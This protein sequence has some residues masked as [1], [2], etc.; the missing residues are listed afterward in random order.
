MIFDEGSNPLK[1]WNTTVGAAAALTLLGACG[2]GFADQ[3][4]KEITDAA[5][6]DMK[7]LSSV[8]MQGDIASEGQEVS[9]DLRVDTDA[10]CQGEIEMMGGT[11]EILSIDGT[12]WFRPDE[13]FWKASAG[14]QADL[15]ISTVGDK[16]V[17][18]PA[19]QADVASFCDLDE[20]L[21]DIDS[22]D[23]EEL[24]KGETEE[25]DG[26]EAVIIESKTDEGD[27][28]KAWVAVDGDH[29]IL[30]MEVEEG[31]EPGEVTFSE[32]DEELDLEAPADDEVIDFSQLAG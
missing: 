4:A 18:M 23:E 24:S 3:S 9:L 19:E 2:S 13:A 16:W 20:L 11:A 32:F 14:A 5:A 12:T 6:K 27:P 8:R 7:E 31:D 30:K 25:I 17:L 22:S 10:N 29:H 15:I 26:E 21:S 28:L 1:K